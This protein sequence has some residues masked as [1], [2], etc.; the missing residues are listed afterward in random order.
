V[1]DGGQVVLQ[2]D[3]SGSGDLEDSDLT[4]RYLWGPQV[5]MLLRQEK[6]TFWLC[7]KPQQPQES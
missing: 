7:R 2:F 1:Y 3:K 4:H 5:D 6:G